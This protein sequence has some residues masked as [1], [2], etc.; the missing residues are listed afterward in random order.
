MSDQ[1]LSRRDL[2]QGASAGIA[3][4]L[5]APLWSAWGSGPGVAAAELPPFPQQSPNNASIDPDHIFIPRKVENP[6]TVVTEPVMGSSIPMHLHYVEM[7][8]GVYAPIGIRK[9]AGNG[10]FPFVVFCHMN[11][12][13]GTQWIREWTQ[14]GSWTLEQFLSAGYAVAW[15]RYRA[16]V[17]NSYG[18]KLQEGTRQGRQ[19]FNRGPLEYDDTISIIKYVKTLP[20][21]DPNRVGYIGVSHGGESLLKICSEYDGLRCGI[22]SEPAAGDYIAARPAPP[23][24][25]GTPEPPETYPELTQPALRGMIADLRARLDM[26]VAMDRIRAVKTPLLIQGRDRDHNQPTFRLVYDLLREAGKEA[27]WKSYDH[28][29]HAFLFVRR[30]QRGVYAPDPIQTQIVRDSMS[31]MDRYLKRA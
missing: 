29:E 11:G 2:L 26:P 9:P 27:E 31:F 10:P 22:A 28:E 5:A 7:V 24:P 19:L 25:A 17:D 21:V 23:R 15:T 20:Y 16:E 4:G 6:V 18:A 13:M 12:G 8:D 14:Y 3:A 1:R 30:N